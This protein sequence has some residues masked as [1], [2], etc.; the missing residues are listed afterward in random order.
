MTKKE[1]T[2][3]VAVIAQEETTKV[4]TTQEKFSGRL[5]RKLFYTTRL[6]APYGTSSLVTDYGQRLGKAILHV[7][8]DKFLELDNPTIIM[9]KRFDYIK[10]AYNKNI[11]SKTNPTRS[12]RTREDAR[13]AGLS[14]YDPKV[15]WP[16]DSRT[17]RG[18]PPE[19]SECIDILL[20]VDITGKEWSGITIPI[21]NKV[22]TPCITTIEKQDAREIN[23]HLCIH[24]RFDKFPVQTGFWKYI[25]KSQKKTIR[26][27]QGKEKPVVV[28]SVRIEFKARQTAEEQKDLLDAL[29]LLCYGDADEGDGGN[30]IDDVSSANNAAVTSYMTEMKGATSSAD[31]EDIPF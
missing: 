11:H 6:S 17:K 10:E 21:G 7:G 24:F 1:T 29:T 28:V 19:A 26:D 22:F 2:K 8:T 16:V 20:L 5:I 4:E 14:C 15:P 27:E 31:D 3:E 25:V 12:F 30:W 18:I 13:E 23:E 9:L